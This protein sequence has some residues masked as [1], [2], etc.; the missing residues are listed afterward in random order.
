MKA[1]FQSSVRRLG[2]AAGRSG[3]GRRGGSRVQEPPPRQELGVRQLVAAGG[4]GVG[5][6]ARRAGRWPAP[7]S[8]AAATRRQPSASCTTAMIWPGSARSS[9]SASSSPAWAVPVLPTVADRSSTSASG[10]KPMARRA[11][12]TARVAQSRDDDVVDVVGRRSPPT[13]ARPSPPRPPAGRRR[14]RRSAPPTASRTPRPAPATGRGTRHWRWPRRSSRP[15]R[16]G[17]RRTGGRRPRRRRPT[18]RRHRED[19]CGCRPARR[20][21]RG[22]PP[23]C[24]PPCSSGRHRPCRRRRRRDGRARAAWMAVAFVLSAYAGAVV[25]NSTSFGDVPA[26]AARARDGRPRH[27]SRWCPRRSW[28]RC[29]CPCRPRVPSAPAMS[30]RRSRQNGR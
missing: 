29:A 3:S 24:R 16:P 1:Y 30:S 23:A 25:A 22:D 8:C 9:T 2:G 13:S 28:R 26:G 6:R 10:R 15:S 5:D 27:P 17:R 12:L 21:R 7:R 11:A 19:R 20:G 14:T 18:R 4:D